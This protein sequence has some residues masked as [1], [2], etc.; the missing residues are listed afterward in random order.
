[1]RYLLLSFLLLPILT[2]AQTVKPYT[3]NTTPTYSELIHQ[4]TQLAEKYSN[5][6]LDTAGQSDCG[7]PIYEFIIDNSKSF[8]PKASTNKAKAIVLI[9]NGIHPGEPCGIDAS[10]LYAR[11][12]LSGKLPDG[13]LK[14]AVV[15]IIPAYNVGGMLARNSTSRINQNGP[16]QYGFRGNAKNLDLDRDFVKMD[17]RNS[18]TF[19]KVFQQWNPDVFL[20]THTTDGADYTYSMT[21]IS[22]M[23]QKMFSLLGDYFYRDFIPY[24]YRY[25]DTA[26]YSMCPYI[27]KVG[28]TPYDGIKSFDDLPRYSAGYASLFHTLSFISEAHM[29]KP[30]AERVNATYELI[31]GIVQFSSNNQQIIKMLRKKAFEDQKQRN[32]VNLAYELDTTN[33]ELYHFKGYKPVEKLSKVTGAKYIYYDTKQP[34]DKDIRYYNVYTP[35]AATSTPKA[36]IIPQAWQ[37]VIARLKWNGVHMQTLPNDTD[38]MVEVTHIDSFKTTSF[39]Y[40]G[41]YLHSGVVTHQEKTI[42][43]FL[44]GDFLI[45]A[46]Q[47]AKKFL[48]EVL[49][50]RGPDSYFAWNFFD[51]VLMQKEYFEDYLFEE[52][53]PELLAH[54]DLLNSLFLRK[55]KDDKEF[56]SNP[57]EQLEFI[58]HQLGTYEPYFKI[59]P[60][61]GI[62]N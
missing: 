15:V 50:P 31:N 22:N 14:H 32:D 19:A 35:V 21:L 40:E 58:Y 44:K 13:V 11:D 8:N 39:A 24:L 54:N 4:Y 18:E 48:A 30:Y 46:N 60:V 43:H 6:K 5:A 38:I 45:P 9:N 36:Y 61:S 41:H 20:D 3:G 42:R 7:V 25:M 53:V 26:K 56:A 2:S 57:H 34:E 62:P 28:K 27:D 16:A 10:Y 12:L 29:L 1:M 55:K 51:S 52:K 49:D 23:R 47:N 37:Q 33:Y 17:S 59:Y